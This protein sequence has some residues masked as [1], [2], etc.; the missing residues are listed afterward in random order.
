MSVLMIYE[1]E[2]WTSLRVLSCKWV[3]LSW[4]LTPQREDRDIKRMILAEH[5]PGWRWQSPWWIC[6]VPYGRMQLQSRPLT[7]HWST[8]IHTSTCPSRG[9]IS[10]A[11]QDIQP[12]CL[13]THAIPTQ[14]HRTSETYNISIHKRQ[15]H[16]GSVD[17]ST[18]RII[19]DNSGFKGC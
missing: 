13:G 10:E 8:Q 6:A 12:A 19:L 1:S 16:K 9:P 2:S 14:T 4:Y 3:N 15:D 18:V 11:V 7:L 5:N 17:R